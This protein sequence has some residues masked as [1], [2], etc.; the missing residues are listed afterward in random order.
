MT[1]TQVLKRLAHLATS[2]C[3][4]SPSG[5]RCPRCHDTLT[6]LDLH[7]P[8]VAKVLR[9]RAYQEDRREEPKACLVS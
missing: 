8:Q 7:G 6:L 2:R 5:A 4:C 1:D 9:D 3:T